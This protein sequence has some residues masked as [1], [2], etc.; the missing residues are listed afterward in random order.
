MIYLFPLAPCL[1]V[2]RYTADYPSSFLRIGILAVSIPASG[3][4]GVEKYY[5]YHVKEP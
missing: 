2:T 4:A 3:E 5:E 1:L